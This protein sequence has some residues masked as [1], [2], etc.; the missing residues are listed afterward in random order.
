MQ[1]TEQNFL[2]SPSVKRHQNPCLGL[3]FVHQDVSIHHDW[4]CQF[5]NQI[6][7]KFE[8]HLQFVESVGGQGQGY[9]YYFSD[10]ANLV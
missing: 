8:M 9:W 1:Q 4:L 6:E 3:S 2:L 5:A 10:I 7:G